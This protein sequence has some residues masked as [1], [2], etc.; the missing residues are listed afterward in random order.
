MAFNH[1][2]HFIKGEPLLARKLAARGY[3]A[4]SIN[5]RLDANTYGLQ[6]DRRAILAAVDDTKAAIRYARSVAS[7]YNLDPTRVA[8]MGDSAG[9]ITSLY[10]GYATAGRHG[11]SKPTG[12]DDSVQAVVPISGSMKDQG[13]CQGLYPNGQP[14]NCQINGTF[15]DYKNVTGSPQPPLLMVH[16]TEDCTV[17]YVDGKE[18]ADRAAAV[19]LASKLITIKGG[20]H[21]PFDQLWGSAAFTNE[22]FTF[23]AENFAK[24]AECP[25]L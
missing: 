17:P 8:V 19:G 21:V 4:V 9:A 12:E 2:S 11:D 25:T 3:V 6:N 23:L 24:G 22:F 15:D 13:F 20:Y 7:E 1:G 10:V 14:Y 18:V 16:G 5:Y